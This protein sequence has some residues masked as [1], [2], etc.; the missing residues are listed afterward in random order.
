MSPFRYVRMVLWSF[1]GIGGGASR[2]E[3]A[4]AKPLALI[5]VAVLLAALFG[6]TLWVLAN[7]AV[8]TWE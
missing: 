4:E 1:I 5:G 8:S 7:L 2:R 6:L 3:L